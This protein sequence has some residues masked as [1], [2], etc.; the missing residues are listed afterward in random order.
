MKYAKAETPPTMDTSISGWWLAAK[1]HH[2]A[3]TAAATVKK[4]SGYN[5]LL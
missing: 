3:M 5:L 4:V 1:R 2:P